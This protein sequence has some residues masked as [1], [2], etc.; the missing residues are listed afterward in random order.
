MAPFEA[1]AQ[2]R[3]APAPALRGGLSPD[4][5]PPAPLP[6]SNPTRPRF[7]PVRQPLGLQKTV[8]QRQE[9]T[10]PPLPGAVPLVV[11]PGALA[12][13]PAVPGAVVPAV[14]VDAPP[15]VGTLTGPFETPIAGTPP[16]PGP[17][18]T[19]PFPP[20]RKPRVEDDPWA[21]LGTRFG[22]LILRPSLDVDA[23]YDS[24]PNR[25]ATRAKG[26]TVAIAGAALDLQSDWVRHSLTANWRGT[27][28]RYPGNPG[29]DRPEANGVAL[30]RLDVLRDTLVEIGAT[31]SL[32]TAQPGSVE[33]PTVGNSRQNIA[34]YGANL[35]VKQRF[36]LFSLEAR[37]LYTRLD[38]ADLAFASGL[39]VPQGYRNYDDYMLRVRAAYEPTPAFQPFVQASIDTRVHDVALDPQGYARDSRGQTLAVGAA[40]EISRILS[41]EASVGYGTRSYDDPRLASLGAGLLDASI[42]WSATPLTQVRFKAQSSLNETTVLNA[43]GSST[44]TLGVEV[45]HSFRRNLILTGSLQY[46]HTTYQGVSI[47]EDGWTAGLKL[48]YKLTRAVV[49]RASALREQLNSSVAGSDYTANVFLVGL[50]LQH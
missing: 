27:Y 18:L 33:Q 7:K 16:Q 29:A 12:P 20:R 6:A 9:V 43:S 44:Q 25:V 24:N 37:G 19:S 41:G 21:P 38:Y 36:G 14:P 39:T 11:A 15:P 4:V 26:S 40:F 48:D 30:L 23:G 34:T 5:S 42:L 47:R 31:Q 2:S 32:T 1:S 17:L 10:A 45:E 22:G 50:R 28:S 3:P 46:A 49:L 35:G 13:S 8:R